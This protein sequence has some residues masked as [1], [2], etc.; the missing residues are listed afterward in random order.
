MKKMA[1]RL[2]VGV[3]LLIA[4][5]PSMGLAE[6]HALAWQGHALAVADVTT[7][8]EA[9]QKAFP[10]PSPASGYCVLFL[11]KSTGGTT[12]TQAEVDQYGMDFMLSDGA[13]DITR[14]SSLIVDYDEYDLGV[15]FYVDDYK[16]EA[17]ALRLR[18]EEQERM[19]EGLAKAK[20]SWQGLEL[21]LSGWTTD[22][23]MLSN[24]AWPEIGYLAMAT[25]GT[26]GIPITDAQFEKGQ[27][28]IVL[29]DAAGREYIC[30]SS[31]M[32][33][34]VNRPTTFRLIYSIDGDSSLPEELSLRVR[35]LPTLWFHGEARTRY[36][37]PFSLFEPQQPEQSSVA[38]AL[39]STA[40]YD[41]KARAAAGDPEKTFDRLKGEIDRISSD[42][43]A[44]FGDGVIITNDPNR[45]SVVIFVDIQYPAG[46]KYGD[47]GQVRAYNSV[48]RLAAYD[49]LSHTEIATMELSNRFG[50]TVSVAVG[51]SVAV[52]D[53]P[54]IA[55]ATQEQKAE[56]LAPLLKTLQA[57]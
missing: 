15:L 42:L 46:A 34:E 9:V 44:L 37:I 40:K 48:M 29:V 39:E 5:C 36:A 53:A 14:P 6:A 20:L 52:K 18:V 56:F 12:V 57:Q 49:A 7:E 51:T 10:G 11:L 21:S 47:Y 3:V 22:K 35:P 19:P 4:L 24:Y 28:E 32:N 26:Q 33:L 25:F 13:N 50:E 1:M 16:I 45:A 41:Y 27:Y 43:S 2:L 38:L 55:D 17:N 31:Y 30:S 54:R 8:Y 23:M